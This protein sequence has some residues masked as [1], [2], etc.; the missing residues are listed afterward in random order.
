MDI[1]TWSCPFVAEKITEIFSHLLKQRYSKQE[2]MYVKEFEC[3]Q[4]MQSK[5][6]EIITQ[7][8][9]QRRQHE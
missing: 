1:F 6:V 9:N 7:F 4:F 8:R 5:L 2:E 3:T